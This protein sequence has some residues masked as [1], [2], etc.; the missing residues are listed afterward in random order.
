MQGQVNN[1]K[2]NPKYLVITSRV[3]RFALVLIGVAI[4]FALGIIRALTQAQFAFAS[5]I[6]LPILMNAWFAGRVAG[7]F[8]AVVG[9][10]LWGYADHVTTS[11]DETVLIPS[12]N[13]IV[14]LIN[15]GIVVELARRVHDLLARESD[16]ARTDKLTGLLNRRGFMEALGQQINIAQRLEASV[17][18]AF[19][20]LDKFKQLNDTH[21]HKAGDAAL[22]RI[23]VTLQ[24]ELRSVDIIGRLGG[25]EFCVMSFEKTADD[26]TAAALR[27]H[28][29]LTDAMAIYKP[30]GVS[31]GVVFFEA[32]QMPVAE[33]L[34]LA[35]KTMYEVKHAGRGTVLV[36][37]F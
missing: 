19:I 16:K 26:A 34:H 28:E 10:L 2:T 32:L 20:D 9:A 22:R 30:V 5:L 24:N 27:L 25:D 1:M 15:Y 18:I 21:G 6:L 29:H 35:D 3:A 33:M 23:G 12:L 36:R 17:A 7:W 37:S 14:H 13:A 8:L 11:A 31:I 4:I